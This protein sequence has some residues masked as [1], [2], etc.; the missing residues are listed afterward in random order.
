MQ[1]TNSEKTEKENTL[2]SYPTES[3]QLC[4]I[5]VSPVLSQAPSSA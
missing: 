5:L 2:F 4:Q 3:Y 1:K